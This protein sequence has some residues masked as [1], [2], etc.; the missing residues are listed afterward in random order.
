ML[1]I[2]K[3]GGAYLPLDPS[4]PRR[5]LAFMIDDAAT[6]LVLT[7]QS[8][9]DRIP[10]PAPAIVRLDGDWPLIESEAAADLGVPVTPEHTAYVIYTSGSTG[11]PKGV[12]I[13]HRGVVRLVCNTNYIACAPP[14]RVAQASNA[15]FD[16]ATFEIWCHC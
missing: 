3:A 9:V 7:Q 5:R 12:V 13:P 11:R 2:L 14:D 15:S 8:L 4:Y 6:P 10:D 1:G 16:A